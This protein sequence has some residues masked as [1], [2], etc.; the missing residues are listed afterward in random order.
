MF[1]TPVHPSRSPIRVFDNLGTDQ[2]IDPKPFSILA[3]FL[4]QADF[5]KKQGLFPRISK[6]DEK[7]QL[8]K[9]KCETQNIELPLKSRKTVG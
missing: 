1:F 8:N 6:G 7:E 2:E 5:Y 3:N 4:S 9:S